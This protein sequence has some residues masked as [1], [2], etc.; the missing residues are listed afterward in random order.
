MDV[1][2]LLRTARSCVMGA[3]RDLRR[4]GQG[5]R[6]AIIICWS[7][8]IT[9]DVG[10]ASWQSFGWVPKVWICKA[11]DLC[12]SADEDEDR[13]DELINLCSHRQPKPC[14]PSVAWWWWSSF[15]LRRPWKDA[16]RVTSAKRASDL[17][18]N[19]QSKA[20]HRS[21]KSICYPEIPWFCHQ[22]VLMI[23]MIMIRWSFYVILRYLPFSDRSIR[24]LAT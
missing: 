12:K 11:S 19:Q 4:L 22:H 1:K 10:N 15:S 3:V 7:I 9:R 14:L 17:A 18:M 13:T 24:S 6:S 20:K 16:Q 5:C 21:E 23:L 2:P 8:R